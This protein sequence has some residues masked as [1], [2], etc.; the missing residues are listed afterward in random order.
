MI[1]GI[2]L[3]GVPLVEPHGDFRWNEVLLLAYAMHEPDRLG[4]V[5]KN[6]CISYLWYVGGGSKQ[7][8]RGLE[9]QGWERGRRESSCHME[10]PLGLRWEVKLP[11]SQPCVMYS[12]T[13][14]G[15]SAAS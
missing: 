11:V 9:E 5:A 14:Y 3:L 2:G 4:G 12:C 6:S 1:L 8:L 15:N 13:P 10:Q 7:G